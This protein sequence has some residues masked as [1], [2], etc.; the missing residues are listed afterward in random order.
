MKNMNIATALKEKNR[1]TGRIS[2]L[3]AQVYKFNT[4]TKGVD[5]D[6]NSNDLLVKLQEEWAFLIDLKTKIT[7]ANVGITDKLV[8]LTESKA[9]LSFWNSFRNTGS[10]ETKSNERKYIDGE[11]AYVEVATVNTINSKTVQENV[12]RVQKQIEDLQDEI[13]N[14]NGTTKI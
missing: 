2:V 8:R 6:F 9:E 13:D 11:W 3:Q 5:Q 14:Y 12:D 7:K 1:I 10:S 4:Y